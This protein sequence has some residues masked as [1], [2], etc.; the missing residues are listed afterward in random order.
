M[1]N[2]SIWIFYQILSGKDANEDKVP[3]YEECTSTLLSEELFKR[4]FLQVTGLTA[5][6]VNLQVSSL[7]CFIHFHVQFPF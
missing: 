5:I 3:R 4:S 6:F 7:L 1:H 2:A